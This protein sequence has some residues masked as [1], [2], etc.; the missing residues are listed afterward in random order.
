MGT[1]LEGLWR[2]FAQ[3]REGPREPDAC[4]S[5]QR[6]RNN[7]N[8]SRGRS[9]CRSKARRSEKEDSGTRGHRP[10]RP[11]TY[12]PGQVSSVETVRLTNGQTI[13]QNVNALEVVL[14]VNQR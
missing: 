4:E 7:G 10:R 3:S 8:A 9:A 13:C 12:P 6:L 5:T 1:A 11:K 2:C 14:S